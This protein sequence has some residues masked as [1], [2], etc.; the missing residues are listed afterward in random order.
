MYAAVE[1]RAWRAR[2]NRHCARAWVAMAVPGLVLGNAGLLKMVGKG[3][4]PGPDCG[5]GACPRP[6]TADAPG[7]RRPT[8]GRSARRRGGVPP[9]PALPESPEEELETWSCSSGRC[10]GLPTSQA[11]RDRLPVQDAE[12]P[13]VH[14]RDGVRPSSVSLRLMRVQWEGQTGDVRAE[15]LW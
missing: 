4:A 10:G 7:P 6:A 11:L 3:A 12:G 8:S 15:Y 5:S 2:P 13:D 1:R 14:S 9:A